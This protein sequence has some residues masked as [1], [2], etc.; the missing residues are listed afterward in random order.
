MP[1]E[2]ADESAGWDLAG[3]REGGTGSFPV[4]PPC[5][6]TVAAT[7]AWRI[8]T[9]GNPA[10]LL[11]GPASGRAQG[12]STSKKSSAWGFTPQTSPKSNPR[13]CFLTDSPTTRAVAAMPLLLTGQGFRQELE[14][15]G[16]LALYVPLEGGSETRLLRRLRA[17]G[18]QAHLTS[19]RGLGD[20][21]A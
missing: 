12:I 7:L 3:S 20:P 17:A 2:L 16:A 15:A 6:N 9:T 13:R 18:Y 5:R 8:T 1:P 10:P 4:A 11:G 19:A 21:D 14:K